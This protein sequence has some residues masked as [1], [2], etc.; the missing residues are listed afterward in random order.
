MKKFMTALAACLLLMSAL[1]AC[2]P[3]NNDGTNGTNNTTNNGTGWNENN[4][5]NNPNP[6]GTRFRNNRM[7]WNQTRE[8]NPLDVDNDG[9]IDD[10]FQRIDNSDRRFNTGER[11]G[12]RIRDRN[13]VE[14]RNGVNRGVLGDT[15]D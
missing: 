15:L 6:T 7:N 8:Y 4:G 1:A 11:N 3:A 14:T 12:W 10:Q 5:T 2:A 13:H 9:I